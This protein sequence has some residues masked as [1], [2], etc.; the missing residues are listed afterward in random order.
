M[1]AVSAP[2]PVLDPIA[3]GEGDESGFISPPW[4]EWHNSIVE[5]VDKSQRLFKSVSLTGQSASIVATDVS[6]L[7]AP[8]GLYRLSY[9]TRITTVATNS[10]SLT[11]T[12]G[13]TESGVAVGFTGAAI[14]TNLTSSGQSGELLLRSDGGTA[15]AYGTTYASNVAAGMVYRLDVVLQRVP[16]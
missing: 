10:S 15:I 7:L 8:A 13:W 4:L 12:L 11:I 5:E 3:G 1:P 16:V 14:T 6:G 2:P 9:Y